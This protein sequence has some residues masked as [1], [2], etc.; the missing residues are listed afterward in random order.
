MMRKGSIED[1]L[2]RVVGE[3]DG[4]AAAFEIRDTAYA[5]IARDDVEQAV[6]HDVGELEAEPAVVKVR[7]NR[8]WHDDGL[9]GSGGQACPHFVRRSP[10]LEFDL[11]GDIAQKP[12]ADSIGK[13]DRRAGWRTMKNE[14]VER[15]GACVAVQEGKGD[16]GTKSGTK[17]GAKASPRHR[18]ERLNICVFVS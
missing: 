2:R 3:R 5:W 18:A 1:E 12:L 14:F 7:R 17:S 15:R 16:G 11:V 10:D 13:R 6:G 9:H 4:D 8:C